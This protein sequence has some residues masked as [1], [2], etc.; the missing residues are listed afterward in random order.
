MIKTTLLALSLIAGI[1][2][3]ASSGDVKRAMTVADLD[4]LQDVSAPNISADGNQVVYTVSSHNVKLDIT[5]SDLWLVPY[6]GGKPKPLTTS[7]DVSEWAPRFSPDG[8][9]IAY[10]SEGKE[11][12]SSQI[13]VM[14]ANGRKARQVSNIAGGVIE[15]SW[16]PDGKKLVLTAFAGGPKANAA[17]TTPPIVI[18]RF[19]FKEDWTGYLG[20]ARR[21]LFTLDIKSKKATQLTKGIRIT[22]CPLGHRTVSGSL[23]SPKIAAMLIVIWTAMFSSSS[24]KPVPPPNASAISLARMLTLTGPHRRF[25]RL[26]VKNLLGFRLLTANGAIMRRGS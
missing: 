7:P 23:M 19:Q 18:D 21:H 24:L 10:L 17:G 5:N 22:G 11:D 26:T 15:F 16:A 13:F 4:A 8:T 6:K 14:K 9:S 20:S 2:T 12:G 3:T 25:G 1:S